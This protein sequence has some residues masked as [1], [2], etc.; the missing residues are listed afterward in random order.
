MLKYN[1]APTT[2]L[3]VAPSA[4]PRALVSTDCRST[5][6]GAPVV[7]NLEVGFSRISE[8]RMFPFAEIDM[9]V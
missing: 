3:L 8:S 1:A 7:E 4:F 9:S 5:V 2:A 6:L